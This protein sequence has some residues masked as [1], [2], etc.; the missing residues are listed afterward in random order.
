MRDSYDIVIVGAGI[1]GVSAAR[2]IAKSGC[3]VRALLVSA[4]D[5]PPYKRT[6]ISKNIAAGFDRDAFPLE[7]AEWYEANGI[8]LVVG[9]EAERLDLE[10]RTVVVAGG[11]T[12]R[13]EKLILATGGEAALPEQFPKDNARIHRIRYARDAERLISSASSSSDFLVVGMGVLGVEVSEQLAS[14]GKRVVLLGRSEQLMPRE[15][16]RAA[17]KRMEGLFRDAGVEL[18]FSSEL[19]AVVAGGGAVTARFGGG[20]HRF[21]QIVVC[22]GMAPS[23]ELA[24]SAGIPTATGILVD[25]HLQTRV[26]S[27]YACGDVAEHGKGYRTH[28]WHAAELQG[29]TAAHNALGGA[30]EYRRPEFR[31]KCEI[32]GH[33]F[34]SA[35]KPAVESGALEY[36][37]EDRYL[38]LYVRD[39]R[40]NGLIMIDDAEHAKF[41]QR[42]VFERRPIDRVLGVF[43]RENTPQGRI[44]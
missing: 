44:G 13:W 42:A 33:Y 39:G 2:E 27:V 31:L 25:E 24:R 41:Y 11:S 36:H 7:T 40:V 35:A 17:A 21:D 5:R 34:F 29:Q 15:L 43:R 28:L 6:K 3:G 30:R 4:E 37:D 10:N 14:M 32:F 1:A 18:A 16:N 19:Q 26:P 38:C 12:V 23:L 9:R 22:V 8:D 20:E